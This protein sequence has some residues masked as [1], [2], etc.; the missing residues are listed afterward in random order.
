[1]SKFI[2]KSPH[3]PLSAQELAT[4]YV[5]LARLE[6]A[7]LPS[8]EALTMLLQNKGEMAK[9]AKKALNLVKRGKPL[10]EAGIRAGLFIGLDAALVKVAD[11]GGIHTEVFRQLAQFYEEKAKQVRQIKSKLLLPIVVLLLALFI[12]PVPALILGKITFWSYLGTTVGVII[13]LAIVVFILW[14]LP[15]WLSIFLKPFGIKY[16]VDKWRIRIPYFGRWTVRQQVRNFLRAL[17]LM[18]QAG[19]PILEALPKAYEV[20]ENLV[21]RQYI[22]QIIHHL[23]KGQTFAEALSQVEE[24]EP[25]ALQLMSTGEQAGSLANMMLHYVKIESEE[26]AIHNEIL[27]AWIPRI[28]YAFMAIWIAYGI[29]NANPF[30]TT[31]PDDL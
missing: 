31:I 21:L 25:I 29:L 15:K 1:M 22:H 2:Q 23:Q 3:K 4:F 12:Q 5:Q 10:S 7:G 6:K 20:V 11:A 9:R 28:L 26:I 19:L 16:F 27:V 30:M 24:L 8:Q 18:L 13:Q 14:H 17:G